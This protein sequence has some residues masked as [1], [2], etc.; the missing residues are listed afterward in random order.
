MPVELYVEY[1]NSDIVN[2]IIGFS[3]ANLNISKIK[4]LF[5]NHVFISY[6]NEINKVIKYPISLNG[7]NSIKIDI[8]KNKL[9]IPAFRNKE[10][11]VVENKINNSWTAGIIDKNILEF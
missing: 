6:D 5:T 8:L 9:I 1:I 7:T 4:I 10:D 11:L 3:K 2:F